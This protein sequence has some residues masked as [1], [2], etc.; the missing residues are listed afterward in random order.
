MKPRQEFSIASFTCSEGRKGRRERNREEQEP[1]MAQGLGRLRFQE[2]L[3]E[4]HRRRPG[5][6]RST[7]TSSSTADN[8]TVAFFDYQSIERAPFSVALAIRVRDGA[9]VSSLIEAATSTHC[10]LSQF[11]ESFGH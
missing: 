5:W 4:A 7:A 3:F 11:N 9:L 1:L 2:Y 10:I 8:F 6:R